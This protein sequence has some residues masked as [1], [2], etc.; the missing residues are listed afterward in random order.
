MQKVLA[1][2]RKQEVTKKA[3]VQG[4]KNMKSKTPKKSKKAAA[5]A[6]TQ[7]ILEPTPLAMIPSAE[8][9]VAPHLSKEILEGIGEGFLQIQPTVVSAALLDHDNLDD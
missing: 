7:E 1:N 9:V 3:E 2:T 6:S 5:A 8:T 4:K